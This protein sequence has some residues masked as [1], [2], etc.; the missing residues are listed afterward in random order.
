MR[1]FTLTL[2]V[3]LL[4]TACSTSVTRNIDLVGIDFRFS[5]DTIQVG[6]GD[7]VKIKFTNPDSIPHLIELTE[8]QQHVALVPGAEFTLIFVADKSGTFPYVCSIPGHE[9]AGMVGVL[10]VE[11]TN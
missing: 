8:F 9:E 4:L 11:P 5:P 3:S 6:Q 2:A 10:I 7:L 1:A